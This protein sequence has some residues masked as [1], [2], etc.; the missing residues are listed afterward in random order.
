[1][2]PDNTQRGLIKTSLRTKETSWH[3]YESP[4]PPAVNSMS[5]DVTRQ[6]GKP[7]PFVSD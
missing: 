2:S 1:M 6:Q 3:G 4:F 7:L 5:H